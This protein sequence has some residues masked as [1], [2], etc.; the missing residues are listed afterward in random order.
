MRAEALS[1]PELAPVR[2]HVKAALIR[3]CAGPA[4]TS[5]LKLPVSMA[6]DVAANIDI[7]VAPA[8]TVAD[9]YTGVLYSALDLDSLET[10]AVRRARRWIVVSSA[11]YGALRLRDR[12]APYR[13]SISTPLPGV[14]P[15]AAT[16]RPALAPVLSEASGTGLVV[17]CRSGGYAAAW[18]PPDAV[19]SRWVRVRVPGVSHSAK[20]TRGLVARAICERGLDTR[21]PEA[22]VEGLADR[23]DLTLTAGRRGWD[24]DVH[25]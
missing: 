22:L 9:L 18:T 21:R 4:A 11:L 6:D 10:N 17:D 15:L 5:V 3:T 14:T 12:V 24:L 16:W 25:G 19:A 13:L 20:H 2:D 7:D 1:F 8:L 23:F